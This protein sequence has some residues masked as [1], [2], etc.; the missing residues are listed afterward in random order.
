MRVAVVEDF[1]VVVTG[2]ARLMA[3]YHDRVEVVELDAN[4]PVSVT[5]DIALVD[6]FAQG[7]AHTQDF[8][9]VLDNPLA[10]RVAI[11]TWRLDED[12]VARAMR[13]G[14]HGY[15]SK[16]LRAGD[17]VVALERVH[18]ADDLVLAADNARRA[19]PSQPARDWPGREF[20]LSEREAEVMALI[21]RGLDNAEIADL[22]YLSRNSVKTYVRTLYQK[23]GVRRRT[24]ALLWGVDHGFRV[25]H[26]RLEDWRR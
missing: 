11:Y 4:R 21:T 17:L 15:L 16:Q 20:G 25:Q 8:D 26:R 19:R 23:I 10:S 5:I 1:S 7:E 13:R 2:L 14:F 9:L 6:S 24:H 22:L 12:L 18:V 3:P